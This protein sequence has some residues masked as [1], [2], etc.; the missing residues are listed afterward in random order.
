MG[1]AGLKP[2]QQVLEV[3]CGPGFFTIPATKI[4]TASGTIY[5]LDIHPLA[6][7]RVKEKIKA[8]KLTNVKTIIANA[9]DTGLP[10]RSVDLAFFFGVPRIFRN[11]SLFQEILDEIY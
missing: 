4:V 5:A 3:G 1:D 10:D 8:E 7:K 2:G 11:E 9:T 6:K